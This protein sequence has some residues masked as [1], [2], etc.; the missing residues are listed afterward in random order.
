M[1]LK[2]MLIR[3]LY[4]LEDKKRRKKK[5]CSK[6]WTNKQVDLTTWKYLHKCQ[7]NG[8]GY[9]FSL[10]DQSCPT[11]CDPMD[12][13]M[14]GFPVHQQCLELAQSHVHQ[15]GDAIQ[16]SYSLPSSSPLALNL[17]LRQGLFQIVGS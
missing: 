1:F 14:P 4:R 15:V 11:L 7:L 6:G 12:C 17:S 10:A 3:G 8:F 5:S 13:S 9:Q 2:S 16:S